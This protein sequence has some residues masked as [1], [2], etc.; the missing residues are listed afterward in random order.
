V[1]EGCNSP[2]KI[3][4][5]ANEVDRISGAERWVGHSSQP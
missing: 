4:R 1:L 5:L 3:L 2:G